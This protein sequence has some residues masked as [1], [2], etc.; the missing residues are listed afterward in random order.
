MK[1]GHL[2]QH[3]SPFVQQHKMKPFPVRIFNVRTN[4][5]VQ[6]RRPITRATD[7]PH[8]TS[9][10]QH[11]ERPGER[12][13]SS[14]IVVRS[15]AFH[16]FSQSR[17]L[18]SVA[19]LL[20]FIRFQRLCPNPKRQTI[21]L[22]PPSDCKETHPGPLQPQFST[23][24]S[25]VRDQTTSSSP[26]PSSV[27]IVPLV[28]I[29]AVRTRRLRIPSRHLHAPGQSLTRTISNTLVDRSIPAPSLTLSVSGRRR[30]CR[31]FLVRATAR[32]TNEHLPARYRGAGQ[33]SCH[34]CILVSC[35]TLIAK[36]L[37]ACFPS[38]CPS[39]C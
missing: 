37:D 26:L 35:V 39:I 6:C 38:I 34:V 22:A 29:P 18:A 11:Q 4:R 30:N 20:S 19:F 9:Q 27:S 1:R 14:S 2:K 33:I 24:L 23:S 8:R 31:L 21:S 7:R 32:F 25:L 10:P 3:L 15:N 17:P 5:S 36:H 12:Q 16:I 28:E 13:S